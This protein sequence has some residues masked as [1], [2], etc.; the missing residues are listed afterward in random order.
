MKLA[1]ISGN[2]KKK[3]WM[4]YDKDKWDNIGQ[5]TEHMQ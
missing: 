3:R 5:G 2:T 4:I 1:N